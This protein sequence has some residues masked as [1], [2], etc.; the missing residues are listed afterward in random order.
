MGRNGKMKVLYEFY[1]DLTKND[2][3][4]RNKEL[5]Q[6]MLIFHGTDDDT[7]LIGDTEKFTNLNNKVAKLIKVPRENHRMKIEN[8]KKI[9]GYVIKSIKE[10]E[11]KKEILEER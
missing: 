1:E 3:L 9:M 4:K 7:A 6:K 5:K 8:L 2:I 10:K 11:I